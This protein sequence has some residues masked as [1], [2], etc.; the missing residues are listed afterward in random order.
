MGSSAKLALS[1]SVLMT[2]P[3]LYLEGKGREG[4]TTPVLKPK[5][6]NPSGGGKHRLSP[7]N[8]AS[9]PRS[10]S[11]PNIQ[12]VVHNSD[13]YEHSSGVTNRV[14]SPKNS[15]RSGRPL[16]PPPPGHEGG[17]VQSY[18]K[19]RSRL[20][21]KGKPLTPTSTRRPRRKSEREDELNSSSSSGELDFSPN[22]PLSQSLSE[23]MYSQSIEN[24]LN[25]K[26]HQPSLPPSTNSRLGQFFSGSEGHGRSPQSSFDSDDEEDVTGGSETSQMHL[27]ILS[28]NSP[29]FMCLRSTWN[30]CILVSAN[31]DKYPLLS[32]L[33]IPPTDCCE[34]PKFGKS[35]SSISPWR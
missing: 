4:Q 34:G 30:N 24:S 3:V 6:S 2:S 17:V 35:F 27:Y 22:G 12:A 11:N 15:P 18:A 7:R 20:D 29:M 23:Y 31:L 21:S 5:F 28:E 19:F 13:D 9:K 1:A 26:Y 8:G 33:M 10:L 32:G 25:L 14:H 16:P